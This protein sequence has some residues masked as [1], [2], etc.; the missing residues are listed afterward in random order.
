MNYTKLAWRNIWRNRKR[1][2][3]TISSVFFALFLAILMRGLQL[4]TYDHMIKNSVEYFSGYVQIHANG[5]HDDPILDNS[6]FVND[7][8][9]SVILEQDNVA[10]LLPR[11]QAGSLIAAENKSKPAMIMGIDAEKDNELTKLKDKL[12][13]GRFPERGEPGVVMGEKLAE[14]LHLQVGDTAV[15]IGQGYHGYS[16]AGLYP[17]LGIISY[18]D[19]RINRQISYMDLEI[20]Q[21]YLSLNG[22]LSAWVVMLEDNDRYKETTAQIRSIIPEDYEVMHWETMS[23]EILQGIEAD[24][25]SGMIILMILYIVIGFGIFGTVLMMIAERKKEFAIMVSVGMQKTKLA[26]LV[27]IETLFI[28]FVG[29]LLAIGTSIPVMYLLHLN[30]LR[31]SGEIEAVFETYGMEPIMPIAWEPGFFYGQTAV[32]IIIALLAITYPL[33]S[34]FKIDV[35]KAIR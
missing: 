21:Q 34:V 15:Y 25:A 35:S 3:I 23:P 18:P 30:P 16:A 9:K 13:E 12:V 32:V 4:G 26:I 1:T 6:F 17:V 24:N 8:L 33:L 19:P 20:A 22:G 31:F 10:G 27:A 11:L 7:S 2:L 14:F 29:I 5:Y 28:V